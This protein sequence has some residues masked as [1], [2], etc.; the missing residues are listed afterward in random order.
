MEERGRYRGQRRKEGKEVTNG[1]IDNG[2]SKGK[3]KK[4]KNEKRKTR[5]VVE[6]E[7]EEKEER[8]EEENERS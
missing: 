8:K 5:K 3:L 4:D 1:K 6:I 7:E 2:E